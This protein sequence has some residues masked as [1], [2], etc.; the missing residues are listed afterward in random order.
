MN[1][2][3]SL[4]PHALLLAHNFV[5]NAD[6]IINSIVTSKMFKPES[7]LSLCETIK[8]EDN[9]TESSIEDFV[10]GYYIEYNLIDN[11]EAVYIVEEAI[12]QDKITP[13]L[14]DLFQFSIIDKRALLETA[15][16]YNSDVWISLI[17]E[18]RYL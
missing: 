7:F 1:T 10:L 15:L 6:S 13:N 8:K 5:E 3:S 18:Y 14:I 9:N 12:K 17:L 11:N 4:L 16:E 2:T